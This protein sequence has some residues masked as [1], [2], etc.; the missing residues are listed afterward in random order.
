MAHICRPWPPSTNTKIPVLPSAGPSSPDCPL[1]IQKL[2]TTTGETKRTIESAK[3][4]NI[5][6]SSLIYQKIVKCGWL[7]NSRLQ[8]IS[9]MSKSDLIKG[10][11][12]NVCG[13]IEK[14][15]SLFFWCFL[16]LKIWNICNKES[17]SNKRTLLA[18]V[19]LWFAGSLIYR[20]SLLA[21]AEL[22]FVCAYISII[23]VS[24]IPPTWNGETRG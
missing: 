19:C 23:I 9:H 22:L 2:W 3:F 14:I 15:L 10:I 18:C 16:V 7:L 6:D 5:R 20:Y 17:S 21:T 11:V 12:L 24:I 13:W 1:K 8:I 4:K